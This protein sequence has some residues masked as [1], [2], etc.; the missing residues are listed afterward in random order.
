MSGERW[1]DVPGFE[2]I[3]QASN[4][5]RVRSL[6]REIPHPRLGIQFVEGRILS[7]SIAYNRNIKTGDP[8]VDLRVSFCREGRQYYFNTRRVIYATF[9]KKISYEKDGLYV[10]NV[11]GNG[12]NNKVSNLKLVTKSEKSQRPFIRD[13]VDSYL[14]TADRSKWTK[15]YGG[16]TRRK[17]VKQYTLK[18]K[19]IAKF[20]SISEAARKTGCGDKEIILVAKG[21]HH[22]THG[23]K[24]RY[25]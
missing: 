9:R 10:I 7:Q 11:D 14:K 19:L 22:H 24:W 5:G 6:D 23:F 4:Q 20:E 12:F 18:G 25:A 3:Y 15:P 8:M 2:G 1:K 16:Y 21:I 17:P 13:R